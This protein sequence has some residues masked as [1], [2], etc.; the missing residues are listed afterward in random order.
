MKT[1]KPISTISYNTKDFL[2]EKLNEWRKNGIIE[3]AM[4]IRHEPEEGDKKAHF[5]VYIKPARLLQTLD[6]EEMSQEIDPQNLDKPLKMISFRSSV[7]SDWVLYSI[8]DKQYLAEKGLTRQNHY[9]ISDI[10]STCEDTLQDIITR[11]NDNRKGDIQ[12]RI[13]DCIEMGMSFGAIL[14]SGM[15]PMRYVHSAKIYY[16]EIVRYYIEEQTIK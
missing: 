1:S 14:K 13:V 10:H 16:D 4:W 12:K 6:L 9:D 7:E 5:H 11:L 15:I 3:F 2:E 8:H